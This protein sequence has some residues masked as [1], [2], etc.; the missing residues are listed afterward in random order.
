L[1]RRT[2]TPKKANGWSHR[3]FPTKLLRITTT[4]LQRPEFW[5]PN[6]NF[7]NIKPPLNNGHLSTTATNFEFQ[8]WSL[9]T[10]VH[11]SRLFLKEPWQE[12]IIY[13]FY[14]YRLVLQSKFSDDAPFILPSLEYFLIGCNSVVFNLGR[15]YWQLCRQWGLCSHIR[16]EI[17]F[18]LDDANLLYS[19]SDGDTKIMLF[20]EK[21]DKNRWQFHQHFTR[22]F[23]V[24]TSF[25]QFF[26]S[27]MYV[28]KTNF[29]YGSS[30]K[31]KTLLE[32]SLSYV[33]FAC[34]TLMKLTTGRKSTFVRHRFQVNFC[35]IFF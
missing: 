27:C 22:A 33:K 17:F 24:P 35:N 34:L 6:F 30:F 26:S 23:F 3:S 28:E 2:Y 13:Y 9:Y 10:S 18:M 29:L 11:E 25:R 20:C 1:I 8:G 4:C 32:K 19:F 7:H 12:C 15:T 21:I 31:A 14:Y 16:G 5:G